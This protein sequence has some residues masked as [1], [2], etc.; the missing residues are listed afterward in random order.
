LYKIRTLSSISRFENESPK[1]LASLPILVLD[2]RSRFID[3]SVHSQPWNKLW[4]LNAPDKK[5]FLM[6]KIAQNM[7]LTLIFQLVNM[8]IRYKIWN[9]KLAGILPKKGMIVH[10]TENL[11]LE[12]GKKRA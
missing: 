1:K 10:E 2:S 6:G 8:F 5:I 3:L 9:Y 4:G 12:I 7:E 11:L